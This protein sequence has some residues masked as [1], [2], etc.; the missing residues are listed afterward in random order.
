MGRHPKP[1]TKP[2]VAVHRTVAL[3]DARGG[4]VHSI[5]NGSRTLKPA[6]EDFLGPEH[7]EVAATLENYAALLRETGRNAEAVEIEA[8]ADTIRGIRR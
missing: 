2:V 7:P 4:T 1:Y 8:R 5:K 3:S 6:E